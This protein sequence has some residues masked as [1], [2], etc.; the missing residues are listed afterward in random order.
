LAV[1]PVECMV[2]FPLADS[3][4]IKVAA[5]WSKRPTTHL[6]PYPPCCRVFLSFSLVSQKRGAPLSFLL[7]PPLQQ[8]F[9]G[10]PFLPLA[11]TAARPR[12]FVPLLLLFLRLS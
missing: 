6:S 2:A 12:I 1:P 4:E 7:G 8:R 11:T 3:R 5:F 9:A 10:S